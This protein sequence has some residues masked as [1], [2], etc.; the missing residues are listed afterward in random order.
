[1]I[2]GVT[3]AQFVPPTSVS[4]ISRSCRPKSTAKL[5]PR[6]EQ[7]RVLSQWDCSWLTRKTGQPFESWRWV[8]SS[9]ER[10][11]HGVVA[12]VTLGS[13]LHVLHFLPLHRLRPHLPEGPH[14]ARN[15]RYLHSVPVVDRSD[16]PGEAGIALRHRPTDALS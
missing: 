6:V 12:M 9:S 15:H 16:S 14:L 11:C 10:T 5:P 1:M 3:V 7:P 8:S 2:S 13:A 4:N